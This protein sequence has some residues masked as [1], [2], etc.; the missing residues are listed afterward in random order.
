[1]ATDIRFGA[2]K[3]ASGADAQSTLDGLFDH[4]ISLP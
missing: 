2:A 4:I 1:M 3:K